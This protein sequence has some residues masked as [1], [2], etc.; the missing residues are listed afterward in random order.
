MNPGV[1]QSHYPDSYR[2]IIPATWSSI[3]H[4]KSKLFT[5]ETENLFYGNCAFYWL[6]DQCAGKSG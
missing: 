3:C 2:E 6:D 1:H 5:N 4:F